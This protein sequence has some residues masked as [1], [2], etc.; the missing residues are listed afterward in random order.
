MSSRWLLCMCG[1]E[2]YCACL[3]NHLAVP[4][5]HTQES[6]LQTLHWLLL[7]RGLIWFH[8]SCVSFWQPSL[9]RITDMGFWSMACY[10]F[11]YPL[12]SLGCHHDFWSITCNRL[13]SAVGELSLRPFTF[14][15]DRLNFMSTCWGRG[16]V[17][18]AASVESIESYLDHWVPLPKS[19]LTRRL[20]SRESLSQIWEQSTERWGM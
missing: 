10:A 13:F 3:I 4:F 12:M 5:N 14:N 11:N 17:A 9:W 7:R 6:F 18:K 20:F 19:H 8:Q 1:W 2:E 16:C 15:F